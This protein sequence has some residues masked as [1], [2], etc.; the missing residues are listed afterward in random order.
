MFDGNGGPA[1]GDCLNE[2][3]EHGPLLI[4]DAAAAGEATAGCVRNL[5]LVLGTFGWKYTGLVTNSILF[6]KAL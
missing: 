6:R 1:E 4:D 2:L 5:V 3:V